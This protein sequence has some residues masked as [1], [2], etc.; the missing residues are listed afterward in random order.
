MMI[1][2]VGGDWNMNCIFAF[3]CIYW[4]KSIPTDELRFFR[5]VRIPPNQWWFEPDREY[6]ELRLTIDVFL[7]KFWMVSFFEM[8]T[9]QNNMPHA[10]WPTRNFCG[11]FLVESCGASGF[12]QS[13]L[14]HGHSDAFLPDRQYHRLRPTGCSCGDLGVDV[15]SRSH[16]ILVL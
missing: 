13:A 16:L 8:R 3:V 14:L 15:N 4:E 6:R 11:L 7:S 10:K 12:L 1:V 5:G 2:L 9:K